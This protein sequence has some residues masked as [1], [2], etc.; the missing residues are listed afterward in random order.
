MLEFVDFGGETRRDVWHAFISEIIS[1]Y[2]F[3]R[4]YGPLDDD[5]TVHHVYGSHKGKIRAT[6]FMENSIARLQSLQFMQKLQEDPL[7]LVPFTYLQCAP[8]GDVVLQTLAVK[9]WAGPLITKFRPYEEVHIGHGHVSDIDGSVY[10]KRWMRSHTWGLSH[11]AAF[12]KNCSVKSGIIL[13]KN[14]VVGER[15]I[16]EKAASTCKERSQVI[17]RTRATIV[18]ATIEG[19]P[20]NI[21]LFKVIRHFYNSFLQTKSGFT[22]A[23][24]DSKYFFD[25]FAMYTLIAF[26]VIEGLTLY[27]VVEV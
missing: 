26:A 23:A 22:I 27:V 11:S 2:N 16:V 24:T 7:K 1:L 25:Y 19:I 10:L 8:F 21:D 12:W 17:E 14:L 13:G 6:K 3:I 15:N 18:A 4:E 5:P 20:S 9:F